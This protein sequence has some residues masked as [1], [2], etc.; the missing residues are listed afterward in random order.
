MIAAMVQI[1]EWTVILALV[2][3]VFAFLAYLMFSF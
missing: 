2:A 3:G 1:V